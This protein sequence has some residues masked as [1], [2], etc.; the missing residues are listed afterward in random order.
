MIGHINLLSRIVTCTVWRRK[1]KEAKVLWVTV[2]ALADKNGM[3]ECTTD[4]LADI[5]GPNLNR[6]Q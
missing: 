3:V 5:A 4:A 6:V 1:S 2:L